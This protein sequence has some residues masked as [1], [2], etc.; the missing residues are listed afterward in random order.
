MNRPNLQAAGGQPPG[1]QPPGPCVALS[2]VLQWLAIHVHPSMHR[3]LQWLALRAY[4][5][6]HVHSCKSLKAH[7]RT[8]ALLLIVGTHA[9]SSFILRVGC[10]RCAVM[11]AR[12]YRIKKKGFA[13]KS[14]MYGN[15]GSVGMENQKIVKG[16]Q[17]I[18]RA[19]W[20]VTPL[21][22]IRVTWHPCLCGSKHRAVCMKKVVLV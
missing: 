7:T 10:C 6:T 1:G 22:C 16:S 3:V 11:H 9:Y 15:K 17:D 18:S 8:R 5:Y 14:S 12:C 2:R 4:M 19:K 13:R 20:Y 21:R